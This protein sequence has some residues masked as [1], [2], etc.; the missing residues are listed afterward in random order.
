[1]PYAFTP[2]STLANTDPIAWARDHS[3]T[4]RLGPNYLDTVQR[5][6]RTDIN[7]N[8]WMVSTQGEVIGL[9]D[10]EKSEGGS[11]AWIALAVHP[12]FRNR[13]HGRSIL[14][15]WLGTPMALPPTTV[16]A[17]IEADHLASI[18]CFRA[19]GFT[20]TTLLPDHQGMYTF[21]KLLSACPRT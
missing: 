6:T 10:V 16:S 9:I 4:C 11:E 12:S 21:R 3:T 17:G 13:G 2:L 14:L 15:S 5:I 18:R 1:M 20:P 7:R 19:A 8:C